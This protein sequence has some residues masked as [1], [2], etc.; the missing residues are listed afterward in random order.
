[1]AISVDHAKSYF[2]KNNQ[3][4]SDN[5]HALLSNTINEFYCKKAVFFHQKGFNPSQKML[6]IQ[7]LVFLIMKHDN[8]SA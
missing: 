5:E 6:F 2:D 4:L 1:M 3:H 8:E 7:A